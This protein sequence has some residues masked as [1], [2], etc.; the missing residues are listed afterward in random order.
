MGLYLFEGMDGLFF[1]ST[2]L[3][4]TDPLSVATQASTVAV[5]GQNSPSA[6]AW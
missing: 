2:A 6:G 5:R 4:M 1:Y 3:L